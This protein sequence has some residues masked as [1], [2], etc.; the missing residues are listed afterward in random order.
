[1]D[2][3]RLVDLEIRLAYQD[4]KLEDLDGL[5]RTLVNRLESTERELAEIK[6]AMAPEEHPS[7]RPP[8]Y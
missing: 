4:R 6:R 7:E 3:E 8:H 2:D 1:M 5:V